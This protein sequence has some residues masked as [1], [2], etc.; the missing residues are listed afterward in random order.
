LAHQNTKSSQQLLKD[1]QEQDISRKDLNEKWHT[2]EN[3]A[4]V[5]KLN[6][7]IQSAT[8]T[9]QNGKVKFNENVIR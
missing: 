4:N 6:S 5:N 1:R 8:V 3:A 9:P 2:N 7:D